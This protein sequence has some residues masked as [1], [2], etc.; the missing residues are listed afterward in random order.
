[1]LLQDLHVSLTTT[2]LLWCDNISTIALTSN[3]VFHAY[4]KHIE[5]DYCRNPKVCA[6]VK[7]I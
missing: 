2:P 7:M 6:N 1:M 3:H 4:M 5:V